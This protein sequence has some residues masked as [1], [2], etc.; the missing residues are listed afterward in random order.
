MYVRQIVIRNQCGKVQVDLAAM[1]EWL[2]QIRSL[3]LADR[4]DRLIQHFHIQTEAN[5]LHLTALLFA[6]QLTRTTDLQI[7][8][9]KG[10]TGSKS[11]GLADRFQ[12]FDRILCNGPNG[13]C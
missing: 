8:G 1:M 2:V 13:R 6:Q 5:T 10:K 9:G 3:A 11:V 12:S 4:L 7:M